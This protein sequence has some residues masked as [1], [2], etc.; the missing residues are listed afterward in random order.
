MCSDPLIDTGGFIIHATK[1]QA[2]KQCSDTKN[3]F[4]ESKCYIMHNPTIFSH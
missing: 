4:N 3:P 1:K 2:E